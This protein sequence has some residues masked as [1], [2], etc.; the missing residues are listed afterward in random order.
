MKLSNM[1]PV[2]N[3]FNMAGAETQTD[4]NSRNKDSVKQTDTSDNTKNKERIEAELKK[5]TKSHPVL[6]CIA[7]IAAAGI[8]F[9]YAVPFVRH[10]VFQ[11]VNPSLV[12]VNKG[13]GLSKRN[14]I[15]F[16]DQLE[17]KRTE[18]INFIQERFAKLK[19]GIRRNFFSYNQEKPEKLCKVRD[20]P[21]NFVKGILNEINEFTSFTK[22][23]SRKIEA[24]YAQFDKK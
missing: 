19:E 4:N 1:P 6:K 2:F 16:S 17:L 13:H 18:V 12:D 24:D 21:K 15:E 7:G 11:G 10:N 23:I 22:K 20:I 8:A 14:F 3:N 9:C 5:G